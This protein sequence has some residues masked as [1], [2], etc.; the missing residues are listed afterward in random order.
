MAACT[1]F[2]AALSFD[3]TSQGFMAGR[4]IPVSLR[5]AE[6]LP[7]GYRNI[8]ALLPACTLLCLLKLLPSALSCF[9]Q[10]FTSC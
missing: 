7:G 10:I 6:D 8:V 3:A 1:V 2:I 4:K 5:L 9:P